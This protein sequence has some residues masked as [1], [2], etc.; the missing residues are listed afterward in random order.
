MDNI[1]LADVTNEFVD[2][3]NR[4]NAN[5]HSDIILRIIHNIRKIKLTLRYYSYIYIPYQVYKTWVELCNILPLSRHAI[6]QEYL[7]SV[8]SV[9]QCFGHPWNV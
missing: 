8:P 2:R 7:L 1:N 3:K 4:C 9:L 6:F 5:K